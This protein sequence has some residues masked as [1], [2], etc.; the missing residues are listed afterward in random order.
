MRCLARKQLNAA[1]VLI[2]MA[3][4]ASCDSDDLRNTDDKGDVLATDSMG[5]GVVGSEIDSATDS[6]SEGANTDMPHDLLVQQTYVPDGSLR[7]EM[8]GREGENVLVNV[9]AR[10]L[11]EVFGVA[12][13]VEWDPKDLEMTSVSFTEVFGEGDKHGVYLAA[14]VNPGSLAIGAAHK[15]I[16]NG[17]ETSLDGDVIVATISFRPDGAGE[18]GLSFYQPRCLVLTGKLGKVD[19][20]YMS[21][22]L[23]P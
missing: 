20:V 14:E 18:T 19:V 3:V 2:L 9:V 1:T 7:F 16:E 22:K 4:F 12:L 8:A 11:G 13:R 21:A 17:K 23:W 6:I 10:N 5:D 15:G